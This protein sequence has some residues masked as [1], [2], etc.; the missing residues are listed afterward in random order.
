MPQLE[1]AALGPLL[2][3]GTLRERFAAEVTDAAR[4]QLLGA[5]GYDVQVVEFV[6]LEHTPKNVLLRAVARPGRDTAKALAE[7]RAFAAELGIDPALARLLADRL[8]GMSA[9]H[10][11]VLGSRRSQ[12]GE[13]LAGTAS[14]ATSWLLVEVRGAWGRDAVAD[15]GLPPACA[16]C[17]GR[18]SRAR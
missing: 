8:P 11:D 1:N 15:S 7:Y 6:E 5:V 18:V 13:P 12:A 4:A 17:S 2:R 14:E 10:S 16:R 9:K 3:H